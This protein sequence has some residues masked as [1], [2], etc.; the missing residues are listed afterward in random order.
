MRHNDVLPRGAS[1]DNLAMEVQEQA[2][3]LFPN[4]TDDSMFKKLFSE[5]GELAEDDTEDEWADVAIMLLDYGSRKGWALE[6][7]IRK[8]MMVNQARKWAVK[9]GVAR[10]V[11]TSTD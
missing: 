11:D 7:A 10:H 4:R 8:K 1:I 3:E 6:S 2:D 9:N 5:V